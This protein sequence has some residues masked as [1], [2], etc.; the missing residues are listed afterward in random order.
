MP[1]IP[2][3]N[4]SKWIPIYD[5]NGGE[6]YKLPVTVSTGGNTIDTGSLLAVGGLAST[7][8]GVTNTTDKNLVTDAELTDIANLHTI[9]GSPTRTVL[10]AV[11][12]LTGAETLLSSTATVNLNQDPETNLYTVATGKSC[13]ITKIVLRNASTSLTTASISIGFNAGT[14]SDVVANA[15]RTSVNGTAVYEV[16]VPKAGAK[17]GASTNVLSVICNTKQGAPA[18]AT[19]DVFGYLF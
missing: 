10:A 14:D 13:I 12:A 2:N 18:T 19:F 8:A 3:P 5:L 6:E 7:T 11:G 9:A 4:G 1:G 17:I 16:I 15:T